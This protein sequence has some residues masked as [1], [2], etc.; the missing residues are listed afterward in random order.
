[1]S[2]HMDGSRTGPLTVCI[3]VYD[4]NETEKYN[5]YTY[6]LGIGVFHSGV[7]IGEQEY[8]YGAHGEES[9]GIF[10]VEPGDAP[11][12]K[13]RTRVELGQAIISENQVKAIITDL[14]RKYTGAS[15]HILTRNCN[16]FT[17]EFCQRIGLEV[18]SWVNRL[19]HVMQY[20]QC[21]VPAQYLQPPT[22]EDV[23]QEAHQPYVPFS[24]EG[25]KLSAGATE[26]NHVSINNTISGEDR[27][28]KRK[29]I[30]QATLKRLGYETM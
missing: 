20:L 30:E 29:L 21:L 5:K 24:G 19:A 26:N 18:P 4:L 3:N 2:K 22:A 17:T 13:F 9:T 15:Y 23:Q 14:G 16:H 8:S 10:W 1:M 7:V 28:V 12:C 11:S 27:E 6:Y 25:R